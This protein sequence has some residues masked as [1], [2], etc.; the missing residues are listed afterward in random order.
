MT[1][2]AETAWTEFQE[3]VDEREFTPW[4]PEGW[5]SYNGQSPEVGV[6]DFARQLVRMMNP[7]LVLETGV[8]QGYMT[9]ALVAALEDGKLVAFESDDQWRTM[10]WAQR[11]WEERRH[12]ASISEHPTPSDEQFATADLTVLDSEFE[13][14]F[15]EIERWN[16][17]AKEGALAIVHDT[18]AREGTIHQS[19]RD[20]IVSLGMTGVFLNN[21]RGCFMAVQPPKEN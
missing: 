15:D 1:I 10:I 5:L 20:L 2:P 16:L 8:G 9:R 12:V 7:V 14:R 19:T 21:P 4:A 6:M 3:S 18:A 11:F 17:Y 13:F